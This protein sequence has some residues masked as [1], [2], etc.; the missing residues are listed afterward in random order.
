MNYRCFPSAIQPVAHSDNISTPEFKELLDHKEL[1]N[2][3]DDVKEDFACP[4][5]SVLFDQQNLSD[6]IRDLR[7]SKESSEVLASGPKDQNLDTKITFCGKFVPFY[8][9]Q[10]NFVF[11]KDNPVKEVLTMHTKRG[12]TEYFS[13]DWW[14]FIDSLKRS[15]NCVMHITNVYRSIR[16]V[17]CMMRQGKYDAMKGVLQHIKY[18]NHQRVICVD[19]KM[20][21]LLRDQESG[22]NYPY[23]LCC[24]DSRGKATQ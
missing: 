13:A 2:G 23:F 16:I 22:K 20:V 19:L 14:L 24:W 9:D 7:L 8:D 21:N 17:H 10:L 12:I 5:T 4:S 11:C 18:N 6:L 1:T 15:L 3:D